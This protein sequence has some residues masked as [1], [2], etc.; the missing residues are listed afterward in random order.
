VHVVALVETHNKSRPST[1]ASLSLVFLLRVSNPIFGGL[2]IG[3]SRWLPWVLEEEQVRLLKPCPR[4]MPLLR[5]PLLARAWLTIL[6][7]FIGTPSA[8]VCIR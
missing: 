4:S 1:S 2:Q 7:H 5:L 6:S 3:S 8:E